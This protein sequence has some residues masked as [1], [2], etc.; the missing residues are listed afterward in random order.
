MLVSDVTQSTAHYL[1]IVHSHKG[2]VAA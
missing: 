2:F 1:N